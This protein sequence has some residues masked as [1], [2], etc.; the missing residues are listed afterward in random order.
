M[1]QKI[2]GIVGAIAGLAT[3][4]ATQGAA[5]AAPNPEGL[6]GARSFAELLDPIPNAL[7]MLRAAD[8][9]AASRAQD[10]ASQ[11][12]DVKLAQYYYHHHHHHHRYY[13][14]YHHH[15]H[16]HHL[17]IRPLPRYFYHHHHHHHHHHH[18]Y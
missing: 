2:V 14:Y 7:A 9:A 15:H 1:D 4:D 13:R 5:T 10:E 17:Y 8:A 6:T 16:H 11:N 12:P 18:Y 3:L